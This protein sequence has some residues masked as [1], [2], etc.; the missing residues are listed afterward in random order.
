MK[1]RKLLLKNRR[2]LEQF[3]MEFIE[4]GKCLEFHGRRLRKQVAGRNRAF[5]PYC[6]VGG[7]FWAELAAGTAA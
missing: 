2:L 1:N 7:G 6:L 5:C 4:F 3:V